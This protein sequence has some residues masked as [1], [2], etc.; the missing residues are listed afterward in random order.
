MTDHKVVPDMPD[1]LVVEDYADLRSALVSTLVR[2]HY[3]CDGVRNSEDA[4]MKLREH[5]YGAVLLTPRMPISEDPVLRYA[6][7]DP[8]HA[9]KIILMTDGES[10]DDYR[11]LTKP[12]NN[13]ELLAKL[14][15]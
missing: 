8:S 9:P 5:Q 14:T 15:S 3:H 2:A 4:V 6:A 12:F 11:S 7:A 1:I 13:E 10:E